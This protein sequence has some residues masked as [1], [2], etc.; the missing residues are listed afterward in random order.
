[1]DYSPYEGRVVR[2]GPAVVMS[3]GAVIVDHGEWKGR[4]GRGQFLK[5]SHG[6]A[7]PA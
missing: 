2:G 1:V 6:T 7:H 5:R 3:R 4:A